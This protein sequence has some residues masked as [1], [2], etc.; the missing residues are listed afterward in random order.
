[1]KLTEQE[2]AALIAGAK[3]AN[4]PDEA[5]AEVKRLSDAML[6]GESNWPQTVEKERDT[7]LARIADLEA[8]AGAMRQRMEEALKTCQACHSGKCAVCHDIEAA[9]AD[10]DKPEGGGEG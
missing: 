9:L 1:M 8:Q 4:R 10:A 5:L 6:R 3:N 2:Y 7:A